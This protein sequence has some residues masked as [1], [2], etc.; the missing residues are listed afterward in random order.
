M[1]DACTERCAIVA[2]ASV[3][4]GAA[5]VKELARRHYPTL[6]FHRGRHPEEA[7]RLENLAASSVQP[8]SLVYDVA[9][10]N[11]DVGTTQENV[12]E[13]I[14]IVQETCGEENVGVFVHSLSGASIGSALTLDARQVE[15]TFNSMAHSFLWWA[16]GLHDR[17]LLAPNALLVALSNPVVDYHLR[18]TGVIGP[19]KAALESYVRVLAAELGRYAHCVVGVRFGVVMTPAFE[20]V[21]PEAAARME[22][23]HR[24]LAPVGTMQSLYTIANFVADLP[25]YRFGLTGEIVDFTGGTVPGLLNY[26]L[27]PEEVA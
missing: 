10:F 26:A 15:K 27:S 19:A 16:Q 4:I 17:N 18:N 5:I 24:K 6:G 13:G 7:A 20:K 25:N 14:R 8:R 2:G 22:K 3:G 23:V 1:R 9:M 21:M 11:R 12:Y